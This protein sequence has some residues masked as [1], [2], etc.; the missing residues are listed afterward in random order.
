MNA[1]PNINI[2]WANI[3]VDELVRSGV[4]RAV[5]SPGSRS[6]PFALALAAH[7]DISDHSV[8]D[9]RSA[10]F[11]ALGLARED[12]RPVCLLCTSGTAAANYYP[13]VCEADQSG[14][15]LLL[16]TAD[17]PGHLR[18]SGAPQTMDQLKLYGDRIRWFHDL[19]QPE[20][21]ETKLRYLRS[22]AC[23]AVTRSLQPSAGPVHINAPLRKPLEPVAA[24]SDEAIPG[25][26]LQISSAAGG[27]AGG[28]PHT[29]YL[30]YGGDVR[31]SSALDVVL[32]SILRHRRILF[33]AGP[34][35][36]GREASEQVLQFCRE[37]NIPIMTEAA[38]QLRYV[39][40]QGAP[41]I[42]CADILLRSPQFR[43]KIRPDLIIRTGTAPTNNAMLRFLED[44]AEVEQILVCPELKRR[45]PSHVV[46][47]HVIASSTGFF[48]DL[49]EALRRHPRN[50]ID[51]AW[52]EM[53]LAAA[54]AGEDALR[55]HLPGG[56]TLPN[57]ETLFSGAVLH[58]LG[59]E[60]SQGG[61]LFVSN[62]MAVR[63]LETFLPSSDNSFDVYFN[64]GVNGID[65]ITSA[66]LGVARAGGRET[67]LVTGDVAFLHDLNA[68]IN[69]A[70]HGVNLT[71]V[72]LNNNGGGIF[73]LLPVRDF[74]P[75]FTRHFIA[76]HGAD[77][78][79]MGTLDGV[80][81][82]KVES[83]EDLRGQLRSVPGNPG[84]DI[85]ELPFDMELDRKLRASVLSNAAKD[86]DEFMQKYSV[87]E[88]ED[89]YIN[90]PL[91]WRCL[92]RV[93]ATGGIPVLFLHGFTRTSRSWS[94]IAGKID[95]RSVFAVDLM[96]H[97]D[98]PVP[99]N[100]SRIEPYSLHYAA[101]HIRLLLD[102]L[103]LKR[104]HLVGYSMGGRT[105][106][107]FAAMN[108][109]RLASLT[110][111]SAHPGIEDET[112]RSDRL[113]NDDA[114]ADRL[115]SEGLEKF[116]REWVD[117]P[118]FAELKRTNPEAAHASWRERLGQRT[119]GLANSLR[120]SGQGGQQPF[121]DVL[122]GL[123]VPLYVISGGNDTAYT[124][125]AERLQDLIPGT[126]LTVFDDTGHDVPLER[127][128]EIAV[129]LSGFWHLS[130]QESG[131]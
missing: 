127:A 41:R 95:D 112:V 30:R 111:I 117:L 109:A 100:D 64:R 44:M 129:L 67:V 46:S 29:R 37:A 23:Y 16:L 82:R 84:V 94:E 14:V 101:E 50:E 131:N 91:A 34:D 78:A 38:S 2:L 32:D 128:A 110:V 65:G 118:I 35:P 54:E 116:L 98:S 77:F 22:T 43:G 130:E 7:P 92:K 102:R 72:E 114:L 4:R 97:G 122:P 18:D 51:L 28:S 79:W 96:G 40:S 123:G 80:E 85:L 104:V 55:R 13:A 124:D 89:D 53:L 119:K 10:G 1:N 20:A 36:A 125:I 73:S 45:D 105:A 75:H 120:G 87:P 126:R 62:S 83:I 86:V 27:R 25:L 47:M 106:M 115:E 68:L 121:W 69:G 90:Y 61:A 15:P 103:S 56:E 60:L 9:E 59:S 99:E 63:D 42:A 58:S 12:R 71:I 70:S 11:F 26:D 76:P 81:Y 108:P 88:D 31:E 33:V 107:Q 3:F 93:E 8:V 21:D 52:T 57:E 19:A 6:T 66:A 39:P 17:R 113:Q 49:T 5:I 74:E 48:S 24:A